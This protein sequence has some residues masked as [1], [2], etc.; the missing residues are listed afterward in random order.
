[1]ERAA[2]TR[3]LIHLLCV[4]ITGPEGTPYSGGL[5]KIDITLPE[6][7]PIQPPTMRFVTPIYHPNI[8]NG[9]RICLDILYQ[10]KEVS[11][12]PC[13]RH[14]DESLLGVANDLLAM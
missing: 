5:F 6:R 4:V 12:P 7:Y 11:S 3:D 14:C 13:S 9:G 10:G 1:M 2:P 8:D